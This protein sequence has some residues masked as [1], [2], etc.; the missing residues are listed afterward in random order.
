M[1]EDEDVDI[2][3]APRMLI[4]MISQQDL[5]VPRACCELIDN[6]FD[7]GANRVIVT[8]ERTA[9]T[10]SDDGRGCER[11]DLMFKLGDS[12]KD[13]V[14]NI[15]RFGVGFKDASIFL[16]GAKG[17]TEVITVRD[18]R[19]KRASLSWGDVIESNKWKIHKPIDLPASQAPSTYGTPSTHGT[20]IRF[21]GVSSAKITANKIAKIADEL[22]ITFTP[23]L[24]HG[25]QI[26]IKQ[27][28]TERP[29]TV[30][31][32]PEWHGNPIDKRIFITPDKGAH[33]MFGVVAE[34][35][36]NP[37]CGLSYSVLHRVIK[38]NTALG[39]GDYRT[40]RV[41][42]HVMLFGKWDLNRNKTDIN[43]RDWKQLLT[44]VF[45]EIE[46]LLQVAAEHGESI[47][48][49]H[50]QS[51]VEDALNAAAEACAKSV[52]S[53]RGKGKTHGT[54]SP[55]E[56]P[57]KHLRCNKFFGDG[58]YIPNK[59]ATEVS[60]PKHKPT[61]NKSNSK[62]VDGGRIEFE[63]C[64]PSDSPICRA[65]SEKNKVYLNLKYDTV[66]AM[67]K[68]SNHLAVRW[69]VACC[70]VFTRLSTEKRIQNLL[71][72]VPD[73]AKERQFENA[74]TLLCGDMPSESQA[75][76]AGVSDVA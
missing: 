23:A 59:D 48:S 10:V 18:D 44:L 74:M 57:R 40:S 54:V 46:P 47:E 11:P 37:R 65:D 71:P 1:T 52:Q 68:E 63:F 39:C 3:P 76:D 26:V 12:E 27:G 28:A 60:P 6:S 36:S 75:V 38:A 67:Q 25:K 9:I 55:K 50:L 2:G 41:Y 16:C 56:T 29:L 42:G 21:T 19:V 69:A 4:G 49:R 31:R 62:L 43:D 7:A 24:I 58:E 17:T 15:G 22:A 70:L 8:F 33:V 61:E 51:R 73:E 53:R 20:T 66:R 45:T 13:G 72:N 34:G 32:S 35:E 14:A 64:P 5:G 30:P